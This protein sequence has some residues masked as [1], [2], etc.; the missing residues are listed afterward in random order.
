MDEICI[1]CL[2]TSEIEHTFSKDELK[3]LSENHA[4]LTFKTGEIIVR[5]GSLTSNVAFLKQGLV[6]LH[7][8]GPV[9]EQIIKI[10][11][12][13]A[14]LTLSSTFGERINHYSV[15]AIE[16]STI[17][18]ID[19]S[20]FIRF[21]NNNTKFTKML[22]AELCKNEL[23]SYHRCLNRTQK[24]VRGS[25]AENIL[26]FANEIYHSDSFILP[27]HREEF[28]YLI[29]ATRESVSRVLSEFHN[30]KIIELN[31]NQIHIL[32]KEMLELISKNG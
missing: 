21:V 23:I 24:Q 7:M 17:C 19:L 15:T 26:Y 11:K 6:K 20:V 12:A 30:E 13:P 27:L 25:I 22:L 10:E 8:K 31:K 18:F 14:Y 1:A 32:N 16:P 29:D 2:L 9:F 5:E 28:G 3:S 4:E